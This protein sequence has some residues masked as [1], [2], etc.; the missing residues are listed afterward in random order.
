LG[1]QLL[2]T[3]YDEAR[4][5]VHLSDGKSAR[6]ERLDNRIK[7]RTA[8]VR[9]K[10][11]AIVGSAGAGA[12]AVH[13]NASVRYVTTGLPLATSIR[14]ELSPYRI[15]KELCVEMVKRVGEVSSTAVQINMKHK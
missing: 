4:T 5:D 1:G 10:Q 12:K 15:I 13:E 14:G 2:S 8:S 11:F 6:E 7:T 9:S 3:A